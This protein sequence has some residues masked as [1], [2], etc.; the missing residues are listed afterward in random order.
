[1]AKLNEKQKRFCDEYL[2]DLN[3]TQAAIRAGYKPKYVN[4]NVHKILNNTNIQEYLEKRMK[5]REERTEITQDDVVKEI[6]AIAFSNPSDFFK[7]IDRP[8]T[9]GGVPV[10]DENGEIKTYKDV[11]FVNTD[12][13]S[14]ANKKAI[15]GLKMGS[16]GIEVKLNDKLK[17]LELLGRHLGVFKEDNKVDVSVNATAKLDSILRQ[18]TGK[19]N[20]RGE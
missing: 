9:A 12:N 14:K 11:E 1:M 2:V 8:I 19:K 13:L 7:I 10:H 3:A 16:N 18:L 5:D 6:A 20:E 15:A 17:A 4:K